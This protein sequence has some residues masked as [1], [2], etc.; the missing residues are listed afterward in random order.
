VEAVNPD[1]VVY[2]AEGHPLS[3][4][5]DQVNAALL[6]LAQRQQAKIEDLE[7]RMTDLAE[8]LARIEGASRR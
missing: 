5:Y 8:R 7:K 2:D 1:W 4:R 3:V 6:G